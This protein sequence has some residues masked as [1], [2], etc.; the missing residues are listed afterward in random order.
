MA[1]GAGCSVSV[2]AGVRPSISNE[3]TQSRVFPSSCS[4]TSY[5]PSPGMGGMGGVDGNHTLT[6][7][8]RNLFADLTRSAQPVPPMEFI[9]SLRRTYP[10][11]GQTNRCGQAG[12]LLDA[13]KRNGRLQSGPA[14]RVGQALQAGGVL[15]AAICPCPRATTAVHV[16][17]ACAALICPFWVYRCV[18]GGLPH[19]AGCR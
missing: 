2:L 13:R 11:F 16:H 15:E 4:L 19:A 14:C 6:V 12:T 10:Q 9:L 5:G 7:A 1:P 18:Q 8:T 17:V 3:N